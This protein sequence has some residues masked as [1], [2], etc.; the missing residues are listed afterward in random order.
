MNTIPYQ[1]PCP[2]VV[3]GMPGLLIT[4][5]MQTLIT[6]Q[7][8]FGNPEHYPDDFG[9]KLADGQEFDFVVVGGGR[10]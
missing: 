7:C 4:Q 10:W 1:T 6:T 8:L 5:M 3:T 9:E 2:G